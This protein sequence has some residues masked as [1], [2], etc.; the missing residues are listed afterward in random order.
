MVKAGQ[1]ARTVKT[2]DSEA[3]AE[4]RGIPLEFSPPTIT[5]AAAATKQGLCTYH[6]HHDPP[7]HRP[8]RY[9]AAAT[10]R[11]RCMHPTTH[12]GTPPVKSTDRQT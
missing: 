6:P 1:S 11:E 7:R 9:D 2:V 8:V 12:L 5:T 3:L 10:A 4:L